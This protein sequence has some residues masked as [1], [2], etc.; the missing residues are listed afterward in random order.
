MEDPVRT[1]YFGGPMQRRVAFAAILSLAFLSPLRAQDPQQQSLGDIARQARK[2]KEEKAKDPAASKSVLTDDDFSGSRTSS[3]A[4]G[5]IKSLD[6]S[7]T[8]L[9]ER[10]ATARRSFDA[11]ERQLNFLEPMDRATLA[12]L[13]LEG[14]SDD[15]PGR[16]AWEKKLADA[17][18][19]YV[20]HGR[21]LLRDSRVIL[22]DL[23]SL[24]ASGKPNPSDPH[25]QDEL[26]RLREIMQDAY[27]TEA[28]FQ[29]VVLEGQNLAKQ[30]SQ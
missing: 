7:Q 28:N 20:A 1:S 21:D 10:F 8:P 3:S 22:S 16:A 14:R 2:A 24:A 9:Q 25:F 23:E 11:A 12:K 19:F 6:N 17:K 26:H 4:A 15:F 30:S 5:G 13:A 27:Q 29:S 18:Q